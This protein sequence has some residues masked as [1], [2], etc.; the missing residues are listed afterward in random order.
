MLYRSPI[1]PKCLSV[2]PFVRL[3]NPSLSISLVE[4]SWILLRFRPSISSIASLFFSNFSRTDDFTLKEASSISLFTSGGASSWSFAAS[5]SMLILSP[6]RLNRRWVSF[7]FLI[8]SWI[9]TGFSSWLSWY[10]CFR[11]LASRSLAIG[12]SINPGVNTGTI[13]SMLLSKS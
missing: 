2:N 5:P 7:S 1:F 11:S 4:S 10:D 9:S 3:K 13:C 6:S 8:L 12:S